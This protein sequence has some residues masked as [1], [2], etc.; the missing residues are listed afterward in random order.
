MVLLLI[1]HAELAVYTMLV[2]NFANPE[3]LA[4]IPVYV[5]YCLLTLVVNTI[6]ISTSGPAASSLHALN[7]NSL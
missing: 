6:Q 5:L 3:A 1:T 4:V 7:D 2:T